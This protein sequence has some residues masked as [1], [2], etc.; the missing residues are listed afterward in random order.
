MEYVVIEDSAEF[1]ILALYIIH[2]ICWCRTKLIIELLEKSSSL[3]K[4]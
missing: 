1:C 4:T 3:K 2:E